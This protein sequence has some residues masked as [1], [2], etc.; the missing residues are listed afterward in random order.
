MSLPSSQSGD[1]YIEGRIIFDQIAFDQQEQVY[2]D[3]FMF[4][5]ADEINYPELKTKIDDGSLNGV[6]GF[7]RFGYDHD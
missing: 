4:V 5:L 2:L 3:D 1:G 7:N 6:V